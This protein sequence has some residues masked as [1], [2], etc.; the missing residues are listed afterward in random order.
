[1]V[2]LPILVAEVTGGRREKP[3]A[4]PECV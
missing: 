1:M 3:R 2:C 4:D